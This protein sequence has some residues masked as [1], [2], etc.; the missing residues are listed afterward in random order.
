MSLDVFQVSANLFDCNS[1]NSVFFRN[2]WIYIWYVIHKPDIVT[3]RIYLGHI[4]HP[5]RIR[6]AVYPTPFTNVMTLPLWDIKNLCFAAI[7]LIFWQSIFNI[8]QPVSMKISSEIFKIDT[9]H[10]ELL[11]FS[12]VHK[13]NDSIMFQFLIVLFYKGIFRFHLSPFKFAQSASKYAGSDPDIK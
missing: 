12:F 6:P 9:Y 8:F 13:R 2:I 3:D 10:H 11:S 1:K 7:S 5:R 4:N